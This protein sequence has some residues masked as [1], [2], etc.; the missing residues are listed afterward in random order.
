MGN[1][2]Y[3]FEKLDNGWWIGESNGKTGLFP[4]SFVDLYSLSVVEESDF[5]SNNTTEDEL[6][7]SNNNNTNNNDSGKSLTASASE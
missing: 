7:E 3:I 6:E 4:A 1:I 5:A 2:V